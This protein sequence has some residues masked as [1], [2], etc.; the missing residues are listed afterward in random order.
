MDRS[1][2]ADFLR[3][4][5]EALQPED[6]GLPRGPRRRTGGLRREEIAQLSGM[7]TDYWSRLEQQRGPQPSDQMLAAIA[8]GL[9]LNADE[10]AHLF[11]LAG[12]PA[13]ETAHAASHV[14]PGMQRIV[15][16]L[17]DT[18][19]MVLTDLGETLV[20][21]PLARALLGDHTQRTGLARSNVYRWY[22]EPATRDVYPRDDQPEHGRVF[23]AELRSAYSNP[24][25]RERATRIVDA[26]LASSA[27]FAEVWARHDV[28]LKHPRRKRFA[29]PEVGELELDCQTL[30]DADSGQVLLV[31]TATPGTPSVEKL[32]LLAVIGAQSFA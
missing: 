20:Q 4:R 14:A 1:Q 22:M 28:R 12:H 30:T 21:T 6:V 3:S 18:P 29:H 7:S 9:R 2:L 24:A 15:D 5:R 25:T 11:R 10:R 17:G 32:E 23:T 13:P 26:L 16:R 8:R 31:F 27:E 19:A